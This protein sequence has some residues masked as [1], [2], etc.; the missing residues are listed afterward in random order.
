MSIDKLDNLTAFT[1]DQIPIIQKILD[2]IQEK[3]VG[4]IYT[5]VAPAASTVPW[6]KI[7]IFD[8]GS[9]TRTLSIR[10]GKDAVFDVN[11]TAI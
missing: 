2:S 10:T 5:D 6:G 4:I 8:D 1:E 7:V 11:L 3:A 9:S